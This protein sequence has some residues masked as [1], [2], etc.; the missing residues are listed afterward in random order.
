MD[1]LSAYRLPTGELVIPSSPSLWQSLGSLPRR[2][3]H[4]EFVGFLVAFV[5]SLTALVVAGA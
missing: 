2:L 4:S 3:L 5:F 1:S